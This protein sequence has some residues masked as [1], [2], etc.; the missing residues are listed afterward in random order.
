MK[1][2]AGPL[3]EKPSQKHVYRRAD[4]YNLNGL[5]IGGKIYD[6]MLVRP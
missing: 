4:T 5:G 1:T 6:D 2:L 3:I